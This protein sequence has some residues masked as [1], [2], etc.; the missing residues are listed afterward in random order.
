MV[1]PARWSSERIGMVAAPDFHSTKLL[2]A[3][4]FAHKIGLEKDKGRLQ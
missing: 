2:L 4:N 3:I 1:K